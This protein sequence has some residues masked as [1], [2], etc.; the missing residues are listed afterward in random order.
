MS[1][2]GLPFQP[3]AGWGAHMAPGHCLWVTLV[4]ARSVLRHSHCRFA[5][6][7][8]LLRQQ[9]HAVLDPGLCLPLCQWCLWDASITHYLKCWR[10]CAVATCKLQQAAALPQYSLLSSGKPY[11]DGCVSTCVVGFVSLRCGLLGLWFQPG[12]LAGWLC[13]IFLQDGVLLLE[14]SLVA[15]TG[16]YQHLAPGGVHACTHVR[17]PR[18]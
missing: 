15:S 8:P 3:A 9:Q 4:A 2:K 6:L 11:C 12:R 7:R 13:R 1:W 10:Q 17:A 16:E 14:G 5:V 18:C